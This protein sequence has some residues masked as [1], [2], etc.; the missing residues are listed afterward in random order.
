MTNYVE[1]ELKFQGFLQ[2][3]KEYKEIYFNLIKQDEENEKLVNIE[4]RMREEL[5]IEYGEL[6]PY[7]ERIAGF[8]SV[9]WG[10]KKVDVFLAALDPRLDGSNFIKSTGFEFSIQC[11]YKAIGGCRYER[12]IEETDDE[13]IIEKGA[14][15]EGL[16][17]IRKILTKTK[18]II[19]IQDR[20]LNADIFDFINE[21]NKDINIEILVQK[22]PYSAKA[23]LKRIYISYRKTENNV[24]I[25]ECEKNKFHSRKILIDDKEGYNPDFTLQ[26]IGKNESYLHKIKGVG[27]S[28][29]EFDKLWQAATPFSINRG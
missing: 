15:F 16:Q 26:D 19:R 23:A 6:H 2:K 10:G 17:V 20:Y 21:L 22:E 28:K 18:R 7:I 29:I 27:T 5:T 11:L 14:I 24:E 25:R 8:C 3:L 1:L 13:I 12:T 9:I 4:N